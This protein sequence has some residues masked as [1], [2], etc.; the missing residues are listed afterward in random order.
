MNKKFLI[1]GIGV[2]LVSTIASYLLFTSGILEGISSKV[3]PVPAPK[4][5]ASGVQFDDSLPKTESCP[6]NGAKYSKQQ[7]SWWEK[8]GPLGIMIEN[9][10]DARPQS[11]LSKAD[12]I[13]EAIAEGGITRFLA[14]YYCQ[15]AEVVGPVR[16]ARTYFVDFLSEYGS[17]PLYAHVGGANTDGPADAIGQIGQY[18]WRLN[19]DLDQFGTGNVTIGNKSTLVYLRDYDRMGRTVATEHTMYSSTTKLWEY[20][21]QERNL[22]NENEDGESW[23]ENFTAYSIKEDL[24]VAKRPTTQAISFNFWDGY[25]D[26]AVDW[27][28]NKSTNSYL[29]TNG[30]QPHTDLN[31]KKQLSVKNVVVL[32]MKE[33]RANDGYEGNLHMIYGTKG[34]GDAKIFIDGKEIDGTWSKKNRTAHLFIKDENGNDIE[35]NRGQIWFSVVSPDTEVTVQ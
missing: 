1:I 12:I 22:T 15:D 31:T 14:V 32:F 9:S 3:S 11:G 6:L 23:D 34:T 35:F 10:T 2:Y 8:H 24:D 13:Y 4:K 21:K 27:K 30:G 5:T 19:N 26:Y 28:Y 20:A 7:R 16:S 33:S 18:G 25:S 29:R 17:F